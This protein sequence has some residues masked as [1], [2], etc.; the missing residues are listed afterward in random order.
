MDL[1][2]ALTQILRQI[3]PDERFILTKR[4]VSGGDSCCGAESPLTATPELSFVLYTA[5]GS[6][7]PDGE[8]GMAKNSQRVAISVDLPP[9]M[10]LRWRRNSVDPKGRRRHPAKRVVRDLERAGSVIEVRADIGGAN[11]QVHR[12]RDSTPWPAKNIRL[13]RTSPLVQSDSGR[14][15]SARGKGELI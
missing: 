9:P 12:R 7:V 5:G 11:R 13:A 10:W 8:Q 6:A 3:H 4:I 14:G 15:R 2:S 1:I